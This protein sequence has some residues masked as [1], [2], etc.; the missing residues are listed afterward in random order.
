MA[1]QKLRQM[2]QS[3]NPL[4]FT[5]ARQAKVLCSMMTLNM[6]QAE[7]Q[8]LVDAEVVK[9]TGVLLASVIV[10]TASLATCCQVRRGLLRSCAFSL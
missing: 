4:V 1:L 10:S 2:A 3:C 7:A 9:A 8:K 5:P 6:E